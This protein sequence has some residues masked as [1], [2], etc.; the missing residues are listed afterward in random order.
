MKYIQ[1]LSLVILISLLK[2]CWTIKDQKKVT[3]QLTLNSFTRSFIKIDTSKIALINAKV[4]D[5]T[6]DLPKQ[7]QTILIEND[8]IL[9]IG[10]T[11]KINIPKDFHSIDLTGKTVIPGLIGMHNHMRLPQGAMLYTSPKLY[12]AS[13]VTTIQTCG[14]GNP[15]EEIAIAK[16]I[17]NGEQPG[18]EIINSGPYFTGPNGKS[19]FIR[20]TNENM[21]RDTIRY[22]AKQGV[23]WFKVY[24]N[25]RPQDLKIIIDE[26]HKNNTKVTGHLCATTY[27]EAADLG[28]DAVEHGFIHS[29]DHADNKEIDVCSGNTNFRTTLNIYDDSVKKIQLKLI[30]HGVALGS[31]LSIFEA[32]AN[33]EADTRDLEVMA[34]FHKK[35]YYER[36]KRKLEKGNEWYFKQEWLKKS[37]QY[38]LQFFKLG[39][40]LVAGPDPGLHNMPG[41]ADQKNYELFIVAGF[42]PEEA[43]K[44]MT[45]NG[46][47]LLGRNDIGPIE[48]GKKANLV[49]LTGDLEKDDSVIRKVEVVF[50]N[51]IGYD[52]VKLIKAVEGN[53]GSENDDF[54]TYLGQTAPTNKPEIFAPNLVSKPDRHE[55]GCVFSTN[56]DEIFFAVDNGKQNE[57]YYSKLV[58]GVWRSPKKLFN[59]AFSYNDPMLSPDEN[60]LYYISDRPLE[61]TKTKKDIDIWFSER[62]S[63][64]WSAPIHAGSTINSEL[65]EYYIS[66]ANSGTMYFASKVRDSTEYNYDIFYA[67]HKNNKFLPPKKLPETINSNRYEADVFIAPDESYVIFCAIR[68]DGF[69]KGDLY[70]SFKDQNGNWKKAVNMGNKIN[71][72]NHELCP[73]ISKDGKYL[74]FTSNRDIYWVSTKILDGFKTK[75]Q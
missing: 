36:R 53:V 71:S 26:A 20:F 74:F 47:K 49:I 21:I 37:M 59:D 56:G 51:G 48:K 44:V 45:S 34:P 18:S 72:K 69:G 24:R 35:A 61:P 22:W 5:G 3:K 16:A 7:H 38:D 68:K 54:M 17:K 46:A 8:I 4:I 62:T 9:E 33:M 41:Y 1:T 31:T 50:K 67:E 73:F 14:T 2:S 12:L 32:Q 63:E 60:R 75:S 15:K 29:Y 30:E 11:E 39:G 25:T 70:I 58:D 28:I 65:N 66:F 57:I 64:G 6:G 55:F 10:A 52:P 43:I 42:K 40:L 19:N 23:K 13:G 27:S